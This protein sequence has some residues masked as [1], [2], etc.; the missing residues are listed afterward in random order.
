MLTFL[1]GEGQAPTCKV[2]NARIKNQNEE[3]AP[4]PPNFFMGWIMWSFQ[5]AEQ[6]LGAP[7][8]VQEKPPPPL[9]LER[10]LAADSPIAFNATV[11]IDGA[12]WDVQFHG[13]AAR[14]IHEQSSTSKSAISTTGLHSHLCMVKGL[15]GKGLNIKQSPGGPL[16]CNAL[17]PGLG[18]KK[19]G[20]NLQRAE[21]LREL[22]LEAVVLYFNPDKPT[23]QKTNDLLTEISAE[24]QPPQKSGACHYSSRR[25]FL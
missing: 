13:A 6:L 16:V 11:L 19:E 21:Q 4:S 24:G 5:I 10:L 18:P 8:P 22:V 23:G 15:G 17:I 1:Q 7:P 20:I 14:F 2:A 9:T 3:A 25:K 12:Q